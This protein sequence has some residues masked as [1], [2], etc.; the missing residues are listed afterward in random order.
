[1]LHILT[2]VVDVCFSF[3]SENNYVIYVL[4]LEVEGWSLGLGLSDNKCF[5]KIFYL[6]MSFAV[7]LHYMLCS[8]RVQI[9]IVFHD[10]SNWRA[11]LEL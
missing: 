4:M 10:I 1:M 9:E 8:A 5:C 7:L 6:T 3:A 11:K 2:R